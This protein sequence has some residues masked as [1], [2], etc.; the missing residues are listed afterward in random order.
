M[1]AIV[2]DTAT[3]ASAADD[4]VICPV[5][6]RKMTLA[7]K[8]KGFFTLP[9]LRTYECRGCAVIATVEGLHARPVFG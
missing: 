6:E 5:C 7:R 9:E 2:R 1:G 3:I 8:I 4:E